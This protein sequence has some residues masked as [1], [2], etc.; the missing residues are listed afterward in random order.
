MVFAEAAALGL[1]VAS[2]ASGGIVESVAHQ[3][4][5][6]LA[7]ERDWEALG[8]YISRFLE[9]SELWHRMSRA[10]QRRVRAQ[11]NLTV[12]TRKLEGL[13]EEVL[14]RPRGA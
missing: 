1:P 12:Q 11:F 4:T 13:Y 6:F 2:F 7:A 9:D 10:G 3:E 8:R 14:R 5:G